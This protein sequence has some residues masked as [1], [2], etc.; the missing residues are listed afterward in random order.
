MEQQ[1]QRACERTKSKQK[2]NQV[3]S[4]SNWPCIILFDLAH[5]QCNG[6]VKGWLHY[7]TPESKGT[8]LVNNIL[9][10]S[11]TQCLVMPQIQFSLIRKIK[12][13]RPEHPL[14]PTPLR[15]VTSHFSLTPPPPSPPLKVDVICV[16][17]L[18]SLNKTH[19]IIISMQKITKLHKLNGR[20]HFWSQPPKNNWRNLKLSWMFISMQKKKKFNL[21]YHFW[22]SAKF[23]N[24][25]PE[26]LHPSWPCPTKDFSNDC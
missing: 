17:P 14:T 7:L 1:L 26:W 8:F 23:R 25:W 20:T 15:P 16:S 11:S 10:F 5:K 24:L 13:G 21:L 2:Q 9:M 4:R 12:I 19:C 3:T 18:T 22:D 6:I